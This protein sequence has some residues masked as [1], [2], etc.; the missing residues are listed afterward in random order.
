MQRA[1][2]D[3]TGAVGE[4]M[5]GYAAF[6]Q[7]MRE[8]HSFSGFERK[9]CFLNTGETRF[10]NVSSA[11]GLDFSE[12]GRALAITDWDHDGDLDFWMYGRSA[13]RVRFMRNDMPHGN[14]TL[15][16]RL[17]GRTVNR[18]AIGAR[19]ELELE[20]PQPR[21]LIKTLHA[22][23]GFLSQ[24]S[25]WVTFGFM[26]QERIARLTVRW[27]GAEPEV[28]EGVEANGRFVIEQGAG[29]ATP[30]APRTSPSAIQPS[31]AE[32]QPAVDAARVLL[33]SRVPMP[34]FSY[35]APDGLPTQ[36]EELQG[37]AVLVNLWASWCQPCL[38]ELRE[39]SAAKS[40]L[41]QAGLTI[42]ALNVDELAD[43]PDSHQGKS[44][45]LLKQLQY[46]FMSGAVA[47]E[48]A[49]VLDIFHR[50]FISLR[51]PLPVPSS[52]LVAPDGTLIAFYRGPITVDQVLADLETVPMTLVE[53]RD[54]AMP[55]A[56][57]W[58]MP[59]SAIRGDGQ[60]LA[61]MRAGFLDESD[62]YVRK[63]LERLQSLAKDAAPDAAD[64]PTRDDLAKIAMLRADI[65]RLKKDPR[66]V[67]AALLAA[68]EI[69]P[70]SADAHLALG[71]LYLYERRLDDGLRHLFEAA[72]LSPE[73]GKI[74][75]QL[76]S[77]LAAAGR[78]D[79]SQQI[80]AES[81]RLSPYLADA[82]AN[83]GRVLQ[84][85]GRVEDAA[86]AFREALRLRTDHAAAGV[87]LAWILS[88]SAQRDG[89]EAVRLV[90]PLAQRTP[91]DLA[92]Q[93]VFAAALAES[94]QFER[95]VQ[96]AQT[97][98]ALAQERR[99]EPQIAAWKNDLAAFEAG[100]TLS[101]PDLS[102]PPSSSTQ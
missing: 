90:E 53:R 27:P 100:R 81:V 62:A 6:N 85:Q 13:P 58:L 82:H 36:L 79:E 86:L 8:G 28:I 71:E 98:L 4:Y 95:A 39:F 29:R 46:P 54:R 51:I 37:R 3:P 11:T 23:D 31:P 21:K 97:A 40:R 9:A 87:Q 16:L 84:L 5:K 44:Q 76:G 57:R 48:T 47:P 68:V 73:D 83:L 42:L 20:G 26:P 18:D 43:D 66:G 25:K 69:H 35:L 63:C 41:D 74:L 32:P 102:A 19:L 22:G 80:L 14:S 55:F 7:L 61:L 96:V 77:A 30:F 101:D 72:R 10:A 56:G 59:P 50:S 88:T 93:R 60:G 12:D 2:S 24:S 75:Y 94:G 15:S 38:R 49:G 34:D 52:F 92:T 17:V 1:P 65:M 99:N 78:Y 70:Q 45:A 33:T 67:L 89:E 64:L 91:G